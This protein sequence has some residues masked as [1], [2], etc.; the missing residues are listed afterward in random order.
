[1]SSKTETI[2]YILSAI[3][4]IVGW[5]IIAHGCQECESRGGLYVKKVFGGY[6]CIEA[7]K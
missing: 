2:F 5:G 6:T 3:I 4:L 1:M 7:T